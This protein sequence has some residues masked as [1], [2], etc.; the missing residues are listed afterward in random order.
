MEP[1]KR[2]G[3]VRGARA[4]NPPPRTP[5]SA[6]VTH[7]ATATSRGSALAAQPRPLR[8]PISPAPTGNPQ[9]PAF[10]RVPKPRP[11]DVSME[12]PPMTCNPSP[13]PQSR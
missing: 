8:A 10:R 13:T 9:V 2:D 5:R 11:F 3:G 4:A 12:V 7:R 6:S 1:L